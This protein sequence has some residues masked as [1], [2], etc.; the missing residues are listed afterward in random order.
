MARKSALPRLVFCGAPPPSAACL[1]SARGMKDAEGAAPAQAH[2]GDGHEGREGM[3]GAEAARRVC[4]A[5]T[6]RERGWGAH[7]CVCVKNKQLAGLAPLPARANAN[8]P[9]PRQC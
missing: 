7:A 9:P 6:V 2:A 3:R 1:A 5:S 8:A 4:D